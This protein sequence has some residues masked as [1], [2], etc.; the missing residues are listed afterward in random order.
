MHK[1]TLLLKECCDV[2]LRC[3]LKDSSNLLTSDPEVKGG[4]DTDT[5]MSEKLVYL[6]LYSW[7][8]RKELIA[9]AFCLLTA[10][11]Q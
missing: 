4:S 8:V 6:P 2:Q 10:V 9:F 1:V 3:G 5:V 11:I 7:L